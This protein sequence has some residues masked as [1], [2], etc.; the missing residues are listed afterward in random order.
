MLSA[1]AHTGQNAGQITATY[2]AILKDGKMMLM[3]E[4]KQVNNDV[5]LADGTIVKIDGTVEK[6]DKT[7]ITLKNGDCID[8]DGNVIPSDKKRTEKDQLKE[9]KKEYK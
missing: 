6:S 1:I 4:G 9:E 2:C 8:Q 7:K 5:K 3:A